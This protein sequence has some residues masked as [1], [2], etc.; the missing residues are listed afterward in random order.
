MLDKYVNDT[1]RDKDK[2]Y[3]F[4]TGKEAMG[5]SPEIMSGY[6]KYVDDVVSKS[7]VWGAQEQ[8]LRSIAAKKRI[9]LEQYAETHDK[10]QSDVWQESVYTDALSNVFNKAINGRSNPAELEK[11]KRDGYT[12]LDNYAVTKGWY[13]DPEMYKIKRKEFEGNFN[14]QILDAYLADGSLKAREFFYK[15]KDSFSPEKQNAYLKQIH[16]EEV[17]YGARSAAQ[18]L[19]MKTPEEAYKEIDAIENID[20]RNATENEYNRLLRH[21]ETIQK[22]NDI[23]TSNE[24]MQR[25]YAAY[26][27]GEDI[28]SIMRDI[29]TSNMSLEQKDKIYKNLK[30]MQELEGVGNNWADYNILLDRAAYNNEDFKT[31][32]LANYNLTKEQY[33]KLA[34]LQRKASANEYTPEAEMKKALNDLDGFN[35]F[36]TSDGLKMGEYKDEV[37]RFLSK[38][39]RMQGAAFDL[40]NKEQLKSIMEG[41]NYKDKDAVNKNID[42]TRELFA[43]AK[44]HGEAYDLM[45]REYMRFKGENKREPNPQEIY[46]MAKRSYNTIENEWKQRDLGKLNYAQGVYKSVNATT[47]KKGETKVLTYY[48][49]DRIPQIS[50]ELGIPLE[51]TSRYRKGDTGSHGKGRKCDV[52]MAALNRSQRELVFERLLSEPAVASIGTSDRNL[53]RKYNN[54]KNPKIRDLTNYDVNYKKAHPNTTM[55]HVNHIDISFDTRFGGDAQGK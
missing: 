8:Q 46:E 33:N 43:R 35:I 14:A 47:P 19:V 41:F 54:P 23:K 1:L 29:N 28:S 6:D 53:L 10:E 18:I 7:G 50:R 11:Y 49:D 5:K 20:L 32:N 4:K 37:V 36:Q 25:V 30:T 17:N 2:G 21:Q 13:N 26:D 27:S 42:E 22:Q 15:N 45:A 55:D 12:I 31:T 24:I 3:L 34:E 38:V 44:K 16:S 9:G 39:E 40:K 51:V 48:A 52:G